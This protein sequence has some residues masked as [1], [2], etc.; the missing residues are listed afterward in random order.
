MASK[1]RNLIASKLR[2]QIGPQKSLRDF[3]AKM[4]LEA[5]PNPQRPFRI[6]FQTQND[7]LA[8]NPKMFLAT[9]DTDSMIP[10]ITLDMPKKC[11]NFDLDKNLFMK[12]VLV[13]G[14][15]K[16]YFNYKV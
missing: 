14:L 13:T 3:E 9:F 1:F 7:F 2:S 5:G 8:E 15:A 12:E 6:R 4:R 10:S 11:L 16:D